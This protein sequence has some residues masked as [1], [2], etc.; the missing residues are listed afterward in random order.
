MSSRT[1]WKGIVNDVVYDYEK[2]S[3]Q[4]KKSEQEQLSNEELLAIMKILLENSTFT[5]PEMMRIMDKLIMCCVLP[6]NQ[7]LMNVIIMWNSIIK[8][9]SGSNVGNCYC[10][11][12]TKL[13]RNSL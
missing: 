6:E 4:L 9:V 12:R 5:R 13:Y 8:S 3:Y 7:K 10:R 1:V 11:Q 2:H